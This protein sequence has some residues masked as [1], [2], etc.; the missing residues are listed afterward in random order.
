MSKETETIIKLQVPMKIG[1]KKTGEI[2]AEREGL[3]SYQELLR[4]WTM[5]AAQGKLK[6]DS[7]TG[8]VSEPIVKYKV[9]ADEAYEEYKSGEIKGFS[10]VN[11]LLDDLD[12]HVETTKKRNRL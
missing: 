5:Q 7:G 12:K 1:L 6:I 3:S 9:L 4:Y 10:N 2:L 8:I 11:D